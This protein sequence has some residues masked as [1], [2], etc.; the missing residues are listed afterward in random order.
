MTSGQVATLLGAAVL[1]FWMVG[2]YNRLVRLRNGIGA[3]WAQIDGQLQRRAQALPALLGALQEPM[4]A[5]RPTLESIESTQQQV[6]AAV[7][8]RR[9]AP[10]RAEAASALAGALAQLDST[11]ARLLAL[12]DQQP[13]LRDEPAVASGLRELHDV[14]PRLA[15]A[16]QLFNDAV[17]AYNAAA[18]QFPTSL[19]TR[20]YGF[21]T[22]G[23]L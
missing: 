17:Q 5:E 13:D 4:A 6:R 15:F 2:A 19:L 21:G 14:G 10:V 11:L 20:L 8:A 7:D 3:A 23:R 1:V 12:L 22:A 16:R 9:A 18:R